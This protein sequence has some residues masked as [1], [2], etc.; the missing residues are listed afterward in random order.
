[1]TMR[2]LTRQLLAFSV[3]L[4]TISFTVQV[5]C[6]Q[7]DYPEVVTSSGTIKGSKMVS[8]HG[9]SFVAFRGIRYAQPP[10]G[11]L[12]FKVSLLQHNEYCVLIT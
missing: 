10:V 7:N 3:I 11:E 4:G 12:R 1:M 9:K 6:D 8:H 5:S 2:D